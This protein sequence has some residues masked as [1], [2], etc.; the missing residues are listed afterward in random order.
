[1]KPFLFII[2]NFKLGIFIVLFLLECTLKAGFIYGQAS[3]LPFEL[4]DSSYINI[5]K[6]SKSFD[7]HKYDSAVFYYRNTRIID[8]FPYE[9][10]KYSLALFVAKDSIKARK[11]FYSALKRGLTFRNIDFF[12]ES[13]LIGELSIN[14]SVY[15]T[16]RSTCFY[17]SLAAFPDIMNKLSFLRG[18]DQDIRH[19]KNVSSQEFN[20]VDSSNQIELMKIIDEIGWPGFKEV[21]VAGENAAFL[22]AQHS[23]R[24]T[25]F[26]KYCLELMKNELVYGNVTLNFYAM[27][28]DRYL[29]NTGRSQIFGTQVEMDKITHE[30]KPKALAFPKEVDFLRSLYSLGDLQDYLEL[31]KK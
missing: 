28:I 15:S 26:Q 24:D 2:H 19:D 9:M 3:F 21:G 11:V 5:K 29:V 1:M 10:Y 30:V 23:D 20:A 13:P 27:L 12:N 4:N 22:I 16:A 14:S 18:K 25:I 17:D 8:D 31:F 6:A 7:L